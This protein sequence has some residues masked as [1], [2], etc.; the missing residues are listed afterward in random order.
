[1]VTHH[2]THPPLGAECGVCGRP[3]RAG[4]VVYR[5]LDA[6]AT[7]LDRAR[8]ARGEAHFTCAKLAHAACNPRA[9]L[10][11]GLLSAL[12]PADVFAPF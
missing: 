10:P 12:S 7:P 5:E 3:L 9:M 11:A 8:A 2:L 1:M 6:P 4:D